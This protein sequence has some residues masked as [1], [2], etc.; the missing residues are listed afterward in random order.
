[1]LDIQANDVFYDLGCGS[2]KIVVQVA[3]ETNCLA[4]KGIEIMKE[5]VEVGN[6][7]LK[8]LQKITGSRVSDRIS[9][10]HGDICCPPTAC[11]LEDATIIFI[12]GVN[13]YF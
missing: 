7:A 3:L 13:S 1:M 2:G 10:V 12:F 8:Q 9:I 11:N 6:R 4:S 5:R